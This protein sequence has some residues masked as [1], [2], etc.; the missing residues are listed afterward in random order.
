A[1]LRGLRWSGDR[2]RPKIRN[3]SLVRLRGTQDQWPPKIRRRYSHG[4]EIRIPSRP[5]ERLLFRFEKP[6]DDERTFFESGPAGAA[7]RFPADDR[8]ARIDGDQSRVGERHSTAVRNAARID[9][10]MADLESGTGRADMASR[11][12]IGAAANAGP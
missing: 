2:L 10:A 12:A 3:Q 11:P 1:R 9:G 5:T 8:R 4:H 7:R 6:V